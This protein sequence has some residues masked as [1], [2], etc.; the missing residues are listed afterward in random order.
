MR[1]SY[2]L[3]LCSHLT[4]ACFAESKAFSQNLLDKPVSVDASQTTLQELLNQLEAQAG[5]KFIYSQQQLL[6]LKTVLSFKAANEPL[7]SVLERLFSYYQV[8]F[9]SEGNY[10]HLKRRPPPPVSGSL[11]GTVQDAVTGER[12]PGASVVLKEISKGSAT[13]INGNYQLTNITPG[14]YTLTVS[15]IGYKDFTL[16]IEIREGENRTLDV[17]LQPTATSLNEVRIE[18]KRIANTETAILMERKNSVTVKDAISAEN[19]ERTASITATQAIQKVTGVSV[20]DGRYISVRGLTERNIVVQLNGSRLSSADPLRSGSVPLDILPAQLLDNITVQKTVTPNNPGDA[21]GAL[22]E[23]KTKSLPDTLSVSFVAQVGF[24]DQIGIGGSTLLFENGNLGFFGQN[25]KKHRLTN[26]FKELATVRSNTNRNNT[27]T[28]FYTYTPLYNAILESRN[29]PESGALA[30]RINAVQEQIDPYLATTAIP[31]PVNQIYS[32]SVS[33]AFKVRGEKRLGALVGI[34]YYNRVE[35]ISG[36]VNN[37]YQL[38]ADGITPNNLQLTPRFTFREDGGIH[39]LL[40]GAIGIVTYKI[41]RYNELAGQYIINQGYESSGTLLSSL[42]K[43]FNLYSYQLGTSIRNF[44]TFQLRGEHKP[45][46]GGYRPGISWNLSSSRTKT[47]L[48]DFRNSI[49]LA[50][51]NGMTVPNF[52]VATGEFLGNTFIPEFYDADITRY[53]RDLNENNQNAMLDLT[54]PITTDKYINATFKTGLWFLRRERNYN[55]NLLLNPTIEP[56]REFTL[57]YL[58]S[59]NG[60]L[61]RVRGNLNEWLTPDVIGIAES[62]SRDGGLLTPGYNYYL[63]SGGDLGRGSSSYNAT[64]RVAAFYGMATVDIGSRLQITGGIRAEDTDT[65]AIQDTTSVGDQV[66]TFQEYAN[67]FTVDQQEIQWLPSISAT[68]RYQ[69]NM[70][71]RVAASRTLNRPEIVELV[72]FST[73]DASQFSFIQGNNRLRNATYTNLDFRWEYFYKRDEVFAASFFF[74]EVTNGLERIFLPATD[75]QTFGRSATFSSLLPL[76]TVTFRNN[77]STGIVY[78]IELE[79]IKRLGFLMPALENLKVGVNA[80]LAYSETQ[81]TP[82][83]FYTITKADRTLDTKRPLF[84]QPNIVLNGNI[85]YDLPSLRATATVY[86]NYT[87][88]RLIEVNTD[89]TPNIYEYPAPQ[90]DFIA[91][92]AFKK[93]F[94]VKGFV[95]NILN[96]QTKYIYQKPG[97]T[98]EYGIFNET[99]YRRQFTRGREVALGISYAF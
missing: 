16:K 96:A 13:D 78:G 92:K 77:P 56:K 15:F 26:E 24:N 97:N 12:L 40:Y 65:R 43:D 1:F 10:V 85:G 33:N 90:F 60:G 17:S 79:A 19:I 42:G 29:S 93:R 6:P 75:N 22:V 7:A 3:L 5:F 88:R 35:Q 39:N 52:S 80:M 9:L 27:G 61:S 74:K 25:A 64:Q 49:L 76:S 23:L 57:G 14:A 87:G 67:R 94:Q 68:F 41:N 98:T 83:E 20:R 95:K 62:G 38:P 51:T 54:F 21:T 48:P 34:N 91:S 31:V 99:Y 89:G 2:L 44:N 8:L 28:S 18:A 45:E 4:F 46:I 81:I 32:L 84:E 50:D 69:A 70:N 66:S 59:I 71:F 30:Q 53:Y 86:F 47:D 72:N 58:E 11:K 55:E 82:A 73:F 37:R 36:G 63:V